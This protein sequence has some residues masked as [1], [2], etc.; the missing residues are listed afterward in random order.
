MNSFSQLLI[1]LLLC[2]VCLTHTD[3]QSAASD[4]PSGVIYTLDKNHSLMDFTAK[5][6]GF[7]RVRG[8]FNDYRASMYFVDGDLAS[9][10]VSA[11]IEVA[12]LDT[13]NPGRDEHLQE[14]FFQVEQYPYIRFQSTA[15]V[16]TKEGYDMYGDLTIKDVTKKIQMPLDVVTLN[17]VDQWEN[18]RIVLET[19]LT[20]D[21]NDYN[22]VY[23]SEF[24][25]GI[26]SDEIKIDISFGGEYYNARNSIFPWRKNSIGTFIKDSVPELGIDATLDK[27]R[28]LHERDSTD[29]NFGL[30]HLY[31]AG[32]ALAQG[33]Q[34]EEGIK[35]FKLAIDLHKDT[36]DATDIS[37]LYAVIAE[38]QFRK[39][40]FNSATQMIESALKIDPLN[41]SAL[42]IKKR[43][44]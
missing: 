36:A 43:L 21:R 20:I 24:W 38:I 8:T 3:A 42:E 25:D 44:K 27:V 26:V 39:K 22:V 37:D 32:L 5:H 16:K 14:V 11:T 19:S 23:D 28:A 15:I 9:S 10:S 41:P 29:Y 40:Q 13:Q 31:R 34:T 12:S 17:G 30:G 33:G 6:A 1:S 18:K 2:L 7:G 4:P 35:V